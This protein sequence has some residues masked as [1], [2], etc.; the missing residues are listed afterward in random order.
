MP[1]FQTSTAFKRH[2]ELFDFDF[3][4]CPGVLAGGVPSGPCEG[5]FLRLVHTRPI[6]AS[7]DWKVK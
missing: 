4:Q 7:V 5:G 2:L 6:P 1:H 3:F